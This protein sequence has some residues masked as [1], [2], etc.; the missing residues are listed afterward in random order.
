MWAR[1]WAFSITGDRVVACKLL[2]I[3]GEPSRTRTCDPLVK[4]QLLYR[5][6]Y[7]PTFCLTTRRSSGEFYLTQSPMSKATSCGQR[8]METS[9]QSQGRLKYS[10]PITMSSRDLTA[11]DAAKVRR[12]VEMN[13]ELSQQFLDG[14]STLSF[15]FLP[16]WSQ[17][18]SVES[19]TTIVCE[20]SGPVDTSPISTPIFSERK[21]T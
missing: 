9:A 15:D 6:S 7:R 18:P 13:T 1:M 4:S 11:T 3:S 20:R 16:K 21:S 5:L 8:R 17:P 10:L 14:L 12:V 2:Q 19:W